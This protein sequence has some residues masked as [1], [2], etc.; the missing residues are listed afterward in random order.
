M[1]LYIANGGALTVGTSSRKKIPR[2]KDELD[3]V[4]YDENDNMNLADFKKI[5]SKL[6]FPHGRKSIQC[7][8]IV[9]SMSSP[10][11]AKSIKKNN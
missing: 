5:I 9:N 4:K 3:E 8:N 6:L 7:S 10:I 2:L 11:F 1:I